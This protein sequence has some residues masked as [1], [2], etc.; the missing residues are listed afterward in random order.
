MTPFLYSFEYNLYPDNLAKKPNLGM[1]PPPTKI[2][3]PCREGSGILG[4]ATYLKT[5]YACGNT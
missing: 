4:C 2:D 1:M 5:I 3:T